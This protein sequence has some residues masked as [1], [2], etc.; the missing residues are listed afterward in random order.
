M[1]N[2]ITSCTRRTVLQLAGVAVAGG[3]LAGCLDDSVSDDGEDPTNAGTIES[4]DN[5]TDASDGDAGAADIQG[6][7][8]APGTHIDLSGQT[9]HWEGVAPAAL[10]GEWNPTL[11]LQKGEE[12]TIG[13]SDGD[14]AKHNL[15]IWNDG[16]EVV[17]DLTTELVAEPGDD[18]RLEFTASGELAKYRCNPHPQMEGEIVI[19]DA[20][21]TVMESENTDADETT[22]SAGKTIELEPGADIRFSGQTAHWEGIAPSALEGVEN[23]TLVMQE[24]E[25]YSI[26]WTEGDG[27]MH[28]LQIRNDSD[29][30]VD[31]LTTG[32]P[33]TD[34]GEQQI[35]EFTASS[36]MTQY[37][38]H[39]HETTMIGSI[40]VE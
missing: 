4:D 2:N 9:T 31:D 22:D 10:E 5:S 12:Y 7:E 25:R 35:L 18:Q 15:E 34:P 13:W 6:I 29:E 8:L 23:P 33:V 36:E 16:D 40:R 28:N 37:A 26:G 1:S 3:S 14:G 20:D 24:G 19:V 38:C 27:V 21:G 32:D 39:P 17:D 11:I 30:V